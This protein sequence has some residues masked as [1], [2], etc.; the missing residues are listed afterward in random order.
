MNAA[1]FACGLA[2]ALA[3]PR[4]GLAPLAW[5]GPAPWVAILALS[6]PARGFRRGYLFGLGFFGCLLGW[7]HAVLVHYTALPL[8]VSLPI[9]LLLIAYLALFP[10]SFGAVVAA[11]ARRSLGGALS[12][13]PV[14]WVGFEFV[15]GRLLGGFPWG[16]AG[17]A[18][19][20]GLALL[21]AAS[22]GGVAL[23]SFLLATTWSAAA[24]L[25]LAQRPLAGAR[26]RSHL[27]LATVALGVVIMAHLLGALRLRSNPPT[28]RARFL[29]GSE[30][31][32]PAAMP[33]AGGFGIALVQ[34]GYGGD[35]DY[36]Q[37]KRALGAYIDLSRG[38]A[39]E[40]PALIV[41]PESNAPFQPLETPGY[42][43]TLQE[44]S[45]ET[46]SLLLLGG[47]GGGERTGLTN[48]A[49]LIGP[50]GLRAR[51][52][53]R[54]LVPYGE[55]VPLKGIFPFIRHFVPE[56]GEFVPGTQVGI[57]EVGRRRIGISIC[58]EMI[59]AEEIT[60]Q[61]R[62]AADLLVN[63]TN[64]SWYQWGGP[65][66]HADFTVLRAIESGLFT[67]RAASTGRTLL[68]DPLGRILAAGPIGGAAVLE[69]WIPP[70]P[71]SAHPAGRTF[72]ARLGDWVGKGCATISTIALAFLVVVNIID[73]RQAGVPQVPL[74]EDSG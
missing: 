3:F 67:A 59:F 23:V 34:G 68:V 36:E 60:L 18:R 49:F 22:L 21:Q 16:S 24:A 25:L 63:I 12:L 30:G 19:A 6:S 38:A 37:G 73:R 64:D 72:Y 52:E 41:W 40:R 44:L 56:A 47:V 31:S 35:L 66:Q 15:R 7:V 32:L 57:F 4:A 13:V 27:A 28:G 1:S 48:S 58:Y 29:E 11:L 20:G 69:A 45:E 39:R 71:A 65:W 17:Y 5:V 43:Q 62:G 8:F 9:W 51:Y 26:R 54:H 33:E 55:Y 42:L 61:A 10:A 74:H 14:L 70:P 50:D 53:K 2:L 46:G